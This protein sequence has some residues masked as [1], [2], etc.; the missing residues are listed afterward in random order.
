[1]L[2]LSLLCSIILCLTFAGCGGEPKPDGLPKLHP[3]TLTFTQGGEPCVESIVTL[4]PESDS[5][6]GTG[7][8]TDASGNVAVRTHG[9]FLGA[10]AGKY[11]ITISKTESGVAGP[12]PADMFTVQTIQTF[13]L[14]DP[15]YANSETTTLVI[16]V[17]EGKNSFPPFELGEKVREPVR[18]PGM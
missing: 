2:R 6:W 7:G 5:P 12:A 15:I 9:K 10:P 3:V 1:M 16:E 14:I 17:E 8:I 4:V 18:L 13:N 11:K